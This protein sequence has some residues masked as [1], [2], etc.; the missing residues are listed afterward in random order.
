MNRAVFRRSR[1]APQVAKRQPLSGR[2]GLR[3]ST[4]T[5]TPPGQRGEKPSTAFA[6]EHEVGEKK[7]LHRV[8]C[9]SGATLDVCWRRSC[10][11]SRGSVC[12]PALSPRYGGHRQSR[13]LSRVDLLRRGR[14]WRTGSS[15]PVRPLRRADVRRGHAHQP[16]APV[17]RFQ[18]LCPNLRVATDRPRPPPVRRRQ[19]HHPPDAPYRDRPLV[20]ISV[21]G[22]YLAMASGYAR[23]RT[24]SD[25]PTCGS[26]PPADCSP[27]IR[28][29]A[30]PIDR[31]S[32]TSYGNFTV[33]ARS[34][35]GRATD[36]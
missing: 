35:A 8:P 10:G 18:G 32:G 17:A 31:V 20:R 19:Q 23:G 5:H 2:S 36:F 26:P 7:V 22:V 11:G 6:R 13:I 29:V 1:T 28:L 16:A 4:A 34:S 33:R 21:R 9:E 30:R 24:S 25:W 3:P 12:R 15:N 27:R 14:R